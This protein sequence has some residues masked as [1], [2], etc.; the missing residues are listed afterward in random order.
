M[1]YFG[2]N[3]YQISLPARYATLP[4]AGKSDIEA[5]KT[6]LKAHQQEKTNF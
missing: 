2:D 6:D 1:D 3:N 4:I 5:F